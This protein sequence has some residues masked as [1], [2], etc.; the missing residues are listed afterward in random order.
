MDLSAVDCWA[1]KCPLP[2]TGGG[3]PACKD[4]S[5]LFLFTAPPD[6]DPPELFYPTALRATTTPVAGEPPPWATTQ[7]TAVAGTASATAARPDGPQ[8]GPQCAHT[9]Q[10]P[11]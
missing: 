4:R 2:R 6:G 9:G 1:L 7:D 3:V 11:M 5:M 8:T 10:C